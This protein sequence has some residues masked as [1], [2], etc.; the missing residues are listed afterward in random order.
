MSDWTKN[1]N[2]QEIVL[3]SKLSTILIAMVFT[4]LLYEILI[5]KGDQT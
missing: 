3:L 1:F 2:F 4:E 5:L